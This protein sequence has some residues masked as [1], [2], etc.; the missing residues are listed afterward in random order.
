MSAAVLDL[1]EMYDGEGA[2]IFIQRQSRGKPAFEV[3]SSAE[4]KASAQAQTGTQPLNSVLVAIDGL[5]HNPLMLASMVR[6]IANDVTV[7]CVYAE[8]V[9]LANF[10]VTEAT[11][12]KDAAYP[13]AQGL[14]M[15]EIAEKNSA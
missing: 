11:K 15:E 13:S 8:S 3:K 6:S 4:V 9:E 12:E 10:L 7:D 2:V 5:Y 1:I 14:M